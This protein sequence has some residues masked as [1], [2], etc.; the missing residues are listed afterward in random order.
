MLYS[1]WYSQKPKGNVV[2]DWYGQR[3]LRIAGVF[4][5][6]AA[7]IGLSSVQTAHA[8]GTLYVA[9]TGAD[10]ASCGTESS[11]CKS[12]QQAFINLRTAGDRIDGEIRMAG[13]TYVFVGGNDDS[14]VAFMQAS[15]NLTVRGGYSTANWNVSDPAANPTIIDGENARRGIEVAPPGA[16]N[17]AF[18][19]L[20]VQNGLASGNNSGFPFGGGISIVRCSGSLSNVRLLNNTARGNDNTGTNLNRS[21]GVGGGLSIRGVS[22]AEQS[23]FTLR[24][25]T[26][27]NNRAIG[28][29]DTASAP[30][31]GVGNG[32][33]LYASFSQ[34]N[35]S[36]LTFSGNLAQGGN[37]PGSAGE[38]NGQRADAVGGAIFVVDASSFTLTD[39]TFSGNQAI[40]GTA[41]ALGGL[42]IGG[43]LNIEKV[44]NGTLLDLT[45]TGNIAR[46]GNATNKGGS[47]LGGA[48]FSSDSIV[49]ADRLT[50][51][52]N[53]AQG[54]TTASSVPG[55]AGG[56]GLYLSYQA[57]AGYPTNSFSATNLIVARN[58][59]DG[60]VGNGEAY[61]AGIQANYNS[62]LTLNH[63]T[64]ADNTIEN[65][66]S[67]AT[68]G[69][70][71]LVGVPSR[72]DLG[73]PKAT[74]NNSIFTSNEGNNNTGNAVFINNTISESN[75][76]FS[77][78]L[79]EANDANWFYLDTGA[80]N[81]RRALT[82]TN[83][84][85][86]DP[87]FFNAVG[88]DYHI[89]S[90]SLARNR[91]STTGFDL[92]R[93]PR[94]EGNAADLGAD[95]FSTVVPTRR[96]VGNG[97]V[98][99]AW[100]PVPVA[101]IGTTSGYQIVYTRIPAGANNAAEGASP[102]SVPAGTTSF[103]LSGLS[104]DAQYTITIRAIGSSGTGNS[105]LFTVTPDVKQI[106]LPYIG[107]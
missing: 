73:F 20:T 96:S 57:I 71:T 39:S 55:E 46:A 11:P 101:A 7:T 94:P 1:S 31:G 29:N 6:C 47:G 75:S 81:I 93:Q 52:G 76:T 43:A 14:N 91:V 17:Y 4:A 34:V 51:I 103:Q 100:S 2:R 78:I 61:G 27:T 3:V 58:V 70:L 60:G 77:N 72:P 105:E 88:G 32:G 54:A 24:N 16:C 84:I 65:G 104:P 12:L 35:A 59:V 89:T 62:T 25:V 95:E 79:T 99:L 92:D 5:L 9:T 10:S 68:G 63:S 67:Y 28:G 18:E 30:R 26:F 53:R 22:L 74:V 45:F 33:G 19:N 85:I 56:G 8:A 36:T 69:G 41:G 98:R 87:A 107:K 64:V 40:G 44:Q 13:G 21:P 106:H 48:I 102:I 83:R 23:N 80:S 37:A 38:L 86:G 15:G 97:S 66:I 90:G 42:G 82:V 50:I 49:T